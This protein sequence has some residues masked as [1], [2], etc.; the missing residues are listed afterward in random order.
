MAEEKP[1]VGQRAKS[2][3]DQAKRGVG[4]GDPPL[5]AEVGGR[6][7]AMRD[8]LRA[9]GEGDMDR[10]LSAFSDEV[11]WHA[12]KGDNFPGGGSHD[13]T[14]AVRD[15]Y[16]ADA[17]RS[18]GS[19]GFRPERYLEAPDEN[20]VV[21]LG[22][23]EG[24]GVEG[25][26]QLDTP[27]VQVWEFDGDKVV[28]VQIF[29]DSDAFS[30]VVT[31]EDEKAYE[32]EQKKKEEGDEDEDDDSKAKGRDD[33]GEKQKDDGGDDDDET[34]AKSRADEEAD[35]SDESGKSGEDETEERQERE[36]K[37]SSDDG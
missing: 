30:K 6:I 20:L 22:T 32:E 24:E 19:F 36:R 12:P 15:G 13:G 10:F 1:G 28:F 7:E 8:A 11:E 35:K 31:E 25:T 34:Q 17:K 18:Y 21:A 27:G 2:L 26:G 37:A 16:I 29:A 5:A 14:E 23:F 9:F 33:D 4:V 3:V